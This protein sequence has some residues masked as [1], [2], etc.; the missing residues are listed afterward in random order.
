MN[1]QLVQRYLTG[2]PQ[3]SYGGLS[4]NWL[5]KECGHRHWLGIAQGQGREL[6]DF[7]DAEGRK[8]Y[9][10][11]TMVRISDA[12]LERLD[13]NDRFGLTTVSIPVG[14]SQHYG[15]HELRAQGCVMARIEMLSA[16]VR[17]ERAGDNR[18]VVRAAVSSPQNESEMRAGAR[19]DALTLSEQSRAYRSSTWLPRLGLDPQEREVLKRFT[20]MP[21]PNTDF[22]GASFLYF[23]S[24]QSIVD[25]AEWSW[26][27][28]SEELALADRELAYHGNVNVGEAVEVQL[29]GV[30]ETA[31]ELTHWCEVRRASDGMRLADV[32]TRKRRAVRHLK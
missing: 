18:S 12:S 4:E 25:R 14:R 21:C 22:N 26:F 13:E 11:F 15:R 1:D 5:L 6:P 10:A 3:M 19:A 2:M 16:F 31:E 30:S 23:A 28:R 8:A 20:F 24:F 27:A 17:R 29:C 7:R 32:L 9:A